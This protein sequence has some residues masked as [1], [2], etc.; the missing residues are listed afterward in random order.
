MMNLNANEACIAMALAHEIN[1][2]AY[3]YD[4]YLDIAFKK[5]SA[6]KDMKGVNEEL[7][8]SFTCKAIGMERVGH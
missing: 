5:V 2:L 3:I 7:V 6:N 1:G 8:K 4:N